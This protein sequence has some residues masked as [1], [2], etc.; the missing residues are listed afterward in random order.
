MREAYRS[1]GPERVIMQR[2][3]AAESKAV[4]PQISQSARGINN[5][6]APA[7]DQ[8]LEL[9]GQRIDGEVPGPEISLERGRP[10]I[11]DVHL[12]ARCSKS[13]QGARGPAL[14]IE[15]EAGPPERIS[16]LTGNR[17]G[18]GLRHEIGVHDLVPAQHRV[19][20]Q[21]A[22]Q[23]DLLTARQSL[24]CSKKFTKRGWEC[25]KSERLARWRQLAAGRE[26]VS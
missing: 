4:A 9:D 2:P 25:L 17:H 7:L 6:T 15:H 12:S 10:K 8:R 26:G 1:K 11:C 20:H 18:I 5:Y 13:E 19:P 23:E 24:Q 3:R 21:S 16:N 14:F 22:C